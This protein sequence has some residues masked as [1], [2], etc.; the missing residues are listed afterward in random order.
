MNCPH[1]KTYVVKNW[2]N[3]LKAYKQFGIHPIIFLSHS[4]K[5]S[6]W[7]TSYLAV[8]CKNYFG[9]MAA[10]SYSKYWSGKSHKGSN[11]SKWKIY[12]SSLN[13]FMDYG[14]LIST[15]Y[16]D[17]YAFRSKPDEYAA[18][19]SKSKYMVDAD[20]RPKYQT[21]FIWINK[22][23]AGIIASEK[24]EKRTPNLL[25]FGVIALALTKLL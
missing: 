21:D 3:A 19:I 15:S 10:G 9:M 6:G 12:S 17:V 2:D 14:R 18:A 7:G 4:A 8:N 16:P 20:N 13:S 5:E 1:C 24:L 11:G 25:V 23:V 22:E